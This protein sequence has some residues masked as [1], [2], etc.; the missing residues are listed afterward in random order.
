[1]AP[2][3]AWADLPSELLLL[4]SNGFGLPLESYCRVRLVCT[5][6]RSALPPPPPMLITLNPTTDSNIIRI[7]MEYIQPVTAFF[8]PVGSSF[9]L[10]T[11]PI[12]S[13]PLEPSRRRRQA[14][15][16]PPGPAPNLS[17]IVFAANP[18]PEHYVA[19]A[20]TG[21]G[22][23]GYAK[24][25]D[26]EWTTIDDDVAMEREDDRL[27]D[28]AYDADAGK[29][30]CVTAYGD[31]R[32]VRMRRRPPRLRQT[33]VEPPQIER[34]GRA[35]DAAAVYAPPYDTAS[36]F[37]RFKRIFFVDGRMYQ[38]WRNTTGAD[39]WRMPGGALFHLA[40]D[41]V[42]VLK[43]G[44]GRR[45]CWDAA[46]DLGGCAVF[47]GKNNPVVLRPDDAPGVRANCVYWIDEESRNAPM[48]FDV[49]TGA[50]T[51]HPSA[52]K[53]LSPLFTSSVCWYFLNDKITSVVKDNGRKRGLSGDDR[54][55]VSK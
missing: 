9:D 55:Q 8:L 21:S 39:S 44:P 48:V 51:L 1:M 29:L 35:F 15:P 3:G 43:Y 5:A 38:L 19:V 6:W 10:T 22:T 25:G 7:L 49:A 37:M 13:L 31:V 4:I 33:I 36:K 52:A 17:K 41:D 50:S 27:V 24:A 11:L 47:V 34:T 42:F 40:K 46:T 26:T 2:F 30:Y 53:V 45:P 54:G 18:T 23:L 20:I 32:V 28:I 14:G 12:G 16:S